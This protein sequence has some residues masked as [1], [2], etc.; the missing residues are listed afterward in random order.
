MRYELRALR[1]DD[2]VAEA[3]RLRAVVWRGVGVDLPID[4]DCGHL[5]DAARHVGVLA[6]GRLLAAGSEDGGPLA[7]ASV[8]Y[9]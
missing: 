4:G 9:D 1:G 6:G 5:D 2:E 7:R 8:R 3:L